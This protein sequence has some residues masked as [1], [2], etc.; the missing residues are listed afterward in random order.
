MNK[1]V[2]VLLAAGLLVVSALAACGGDEGSPAIADVSKQELAQPA[3]TRSAS[4]AKARVFFIQP[5]DGAILASPIRLEFGVEGMALVPAGTKQ[6]AAGH[7]HLLVD[8][9]IPAL[10]KPVPKDANHIHLGDGS[11]SIELS[12]DPGQHSLQ[13]LLADHSH[14]PHDP[15]VVSEK[16]SITIQ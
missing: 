7:H 13:L 8:T 15:P 2:S 3:T 4:A 9:D 1:T 5:T 16:I 11:A 10:D 12:L 14:I 6:S